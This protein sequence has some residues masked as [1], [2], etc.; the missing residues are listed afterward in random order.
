[1]IIRREKPEEQLDVENLIREAFWN[2]QEPGANEHF[3][4]H[5]MRKHE[6]FVPEL[7]LVALVDGQIVGVI[8]YTVGR[9]SAEDGTVKT[10]LTFGPIA[11]LP[12]YQRR[13]IGK[14]LIEH[15]FA[16]TRELDYESV[17]IFGHPSNYVARGFV[18]CARVNV[19]L[20]NGVFPTAMLVKPLT[21][22]VFDG[23]RWVF[24]ES[25]AYEIDSQ[26]AEAFDKLFPPKEKLVLPCQ[27][28]F[29]IYSHSSVHIG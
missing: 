19:C 10:C 7:D 17:V 6:D 27:E 13:G 14:A 3:L 23:R 9:L 25:P 20:A 1:M 22:H 4:A 21:E 29:F 5:Q 11:V 26:E 15:S 8:L 2:A 28:E 16:L 24:H 12:N 18:S